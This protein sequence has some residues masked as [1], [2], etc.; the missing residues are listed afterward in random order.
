M[1][2]RLL[3]VA[4]LHALEINDGE[5]PHQMLAAVVWPGRDWSEEARARLTEC[6]WCRVRP[7]AR[8]AVAPG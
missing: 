3:T 4:E 7:T 2:D 8:S 5:D 6:F 1:T